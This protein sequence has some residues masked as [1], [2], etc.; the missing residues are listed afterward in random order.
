VCPGGCS[1]LAVADGVNWGERPR[2]A[3]R[4]AVYGVIRH[5]LV[6]LL[7]KYQEQ[8][9]NSNQVRRRGRRW[10]GTSGM[11]HRGSITC[12]AAGPHLPCELVLEAASVGQGD[13]CPC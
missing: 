8:E 5:M 2:R 1:L 7:H 4:A 6:Q 11:C 13:V 3:A 10:L 12:L 9:V